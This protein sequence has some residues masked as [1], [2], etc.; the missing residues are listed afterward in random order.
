M[1]GVVRQQFSVCTLTKRKG[2][3]SKVFLLQMCR[4]LQIFILKMIEKIREN[5]Y[6]LQEVKLKPVESFPQGLL[7]HPQDRIGNA[8]FLPLQ[9]ELPVNFG[10]INLHSNSQT[11]KVSP[12]IDPWLQRNLGQYNH[13]KHN[14]LCYRKYYNT[15]GYM[16]PFQ[17][18][19]YWFSNR[20]LLQSKSNISQF[21]NLRFQSPK[22][23]LFVALYF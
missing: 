18:Q 11:Y 8:N 6:S 21:H 20:T 7:T 5:P 14:R 19:Y 22:G 9:I 4:F 23:K 15:I 3:V 10:S 17:M 1:P 2:G 13:K 16:A 12:I